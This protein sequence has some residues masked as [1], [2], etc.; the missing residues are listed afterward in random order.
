MI[1]RLRYV[2]FPT[3]SN[4]FIDWKVPDE[5]LKYYFSAFEDPKFTQKF[6]SDIQFQQQYDKLINNRI[7][8][9]RLVNYYYQ[10]D[11]PFDTPCNIYFNKKSMVSFD[12]DDYYYKFWE[13]IKNAT[14][15]SLTLSNEDLKKLQN[16]H[17][18]K[19]QEI[20]DKNQSEYRQFICYDSRSDEASRPFRVNKNYIKDNSWHPFGT[21]ANFVQQVSKET[22]VNN[23]VLDTLVFMLKYLN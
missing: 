16:N 8:T 10:K 2:F 18:I 15:Y 4:K 9:C 6:F 5:Y 1:T 11:L 23:F 14:F 13:F 3:I 17:C 21:F 7:I 19:Y 12:N 20:L 22:K